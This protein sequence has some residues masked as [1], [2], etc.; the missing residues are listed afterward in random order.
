MEVFAKA[1]VC[2]EP[3][4]EGEELAKDPQH[5]ARELFVRARDAQRNVEVTHVRTPLRFG[6]LPVRPPPALGQ[7]SREVLGEAGF[8][9]DEMTGLGL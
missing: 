3:V 4:L 2:V 5:Q 1:D 7:H 6:P 8:S 9:E